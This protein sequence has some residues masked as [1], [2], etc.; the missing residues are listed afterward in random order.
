MPYRIANREE[1]E[2]VSVEHTCLNGASRYYAETNTGEHLQGR[3]RWGENV[4]HCQ[5]CGE[6]AP[7]NISQLEGTP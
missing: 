2:L 4:W 6:K 3:L 5:Y 7:T 1:V